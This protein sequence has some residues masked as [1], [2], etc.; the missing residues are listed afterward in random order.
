MSVCVCLCCKFVYV[1]RLRCESD[2]HV[3][4]ESCHDTDKSTYI[5]HLHFL[6][7]SLSHGC[8]W[9]MLK[10]KNKEFQPDD[11]WRRTQKAYHIVKTLSRGFC[12]SLGSCQIYR[13]AL[14]L[15]K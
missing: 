2:V 11:Y 7:Y 15:M 5:I 6:D 12:C 10:C 3:L 1:F 13:Q 8:L 4:C 14:N 9:G